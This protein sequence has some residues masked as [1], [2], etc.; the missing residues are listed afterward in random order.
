MRPLLRWI[1]RY[2]II[3]CDGGA[4]K[5][6]HDLAGEVC[7]FRLGL[8]IDQCKRGGK[9]ASVQLG[10]LIKSFPGVSEQRLKEAIAAVVCRSVS[11]VARSCSHRPIGRG[12]KHTIIP[13]L[14][15]PMS[16]RVQ[17]KVVTAKLRKS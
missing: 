2:P 14:M 1:C 3:M 15:I 7:E 10:K 8:S 16:L 9:M 17:A 13:S 12:G 4:V 11:K 5:L 6:G